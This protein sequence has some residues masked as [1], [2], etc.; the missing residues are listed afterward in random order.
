MRVMWVSIDE[1]AFSS[2]GSDM[3]GALYLF[4]DVIDYIINLMKGAEDKLASIIGLWY[5]LLNVLIKYR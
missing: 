4:G 5:M 1:L 3:V 2:V